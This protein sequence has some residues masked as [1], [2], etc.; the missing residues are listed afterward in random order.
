VPF[1]P[2]SS[3]A[4]ESTQKKIIEWHDRKIEPGA[5]WETEISAQLESAHLILLLISSDFLDSD[6]CFGVEVEK[7]F[8][9][10]TT[11][12]VDRKME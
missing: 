1:L 12:V 9:H 2:F 3:P 11:T 10:L 5:K 6:Y 8:T 4:A 7:A